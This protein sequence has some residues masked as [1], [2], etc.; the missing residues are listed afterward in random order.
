[1]LAISD[2]YPAQAVHWAAFGRGISFG[3]S[4]SL[5][6]EKVDCVLLPPKINYMMNAR[7]V[8]LMPVICMFYVMK[9]KCIGWRALSA[10]AYE[11]V[12]AFKAM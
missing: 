11:R 3:N 10:Y 12:C 6:A 5:A 4:I 9:I 7:N 8:T 2:H 1:M